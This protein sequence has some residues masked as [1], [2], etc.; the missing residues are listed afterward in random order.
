MLTPGA[1]K[2]CVMAALAAASTTAAAAQTAPPDSCEATGADTAQSAPASSRQAAIEQ[3]QAAKVSNAAPLHPN[4]AERIFRAGRHRPGGRHAAVAPLLRQR[5]FGRRLHAWRRPRDLRERLQ[6]H[7][8]ARQLLRSRT[9]SAPR[10]SSSRRGCSTAGR[11]CRCSAAGARRRRS[12]STASARTR[13]TTIAP[14]T[15]FSSRT[16][17]RSSPSSRR[18]RS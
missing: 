7:R 3:E 1:L 12:A 13:R 2:L 5:L 10:P 18:A 16:A 8:R 4:K 17:A 9:T 11:N 6:L 14:T 15:C